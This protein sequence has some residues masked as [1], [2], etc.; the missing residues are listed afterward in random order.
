VHQL[1]NL[2]T[3]LRRLA[4]LTS[5]GGVLVIVGLARPTTMWDHMLSH[6]RRTSPMAVK[7]ATSLGALGARGAARALLPTSP[8]HRSGDVA[9]GC[10]GVAN[11]A[12][13]CRPPWSLA[14][15]VGI[16]IPSIEGIAQPVTRLAY[17]VHVVGL[18]FTSM[19][20]VP[21]AF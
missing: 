8:S 4:D 2:R 3:P 5:P 18:R 6:G 11:I 9:A 12:V 20:R 21:S 10:D 1:P 13:R 7:D 17:S 19:N 14:L 16:R 15:V